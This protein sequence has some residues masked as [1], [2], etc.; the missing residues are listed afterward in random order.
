MFLR[1]ADF[2]VIKSK[3]ILHISRVLLRDNCEM[4]KKTTH[5]F[6]HRKE[7]HKHETDGTKNLS[8]VT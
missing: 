3:F 7:K 8:V 1:N 5:L 4:L 6:L 2:E